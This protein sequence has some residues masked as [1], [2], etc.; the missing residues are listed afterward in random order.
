MGSQPKEDPPHRKQDRKHRSTEWLNQLLESRYRE[1]F[2]DD[3]LA[4]DIPLV[5]QLNIEG[6]KQVN[7]LQATPWRLLEKPKYPNSP[8]FQGKVNVSRKGSVGRTAGS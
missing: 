7:V 8:M 2:G 4:E 1:L 3:H 6:N 5:N